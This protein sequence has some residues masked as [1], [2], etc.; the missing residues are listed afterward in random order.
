MV[1]NKKESSHS[2]IGSLHMLQK[3]IASMQ[4]IRMLPKILPAR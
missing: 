3:A 1:P 4:T 2:T